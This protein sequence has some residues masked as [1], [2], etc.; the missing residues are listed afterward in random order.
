M[1]LWNENIWNTFYISTKTLWVWIKSKKLWGVDKKL[2][3]IEK[4][5]QFLIR[6][7][8]ES[9]ISKSTWEWLVFKIFL[10]FS[11]SLIEYGT[12]INYGFKPMKISRKWYFN[13]KL[14]FNEKIMIVHFYTNELVNYIHVIDIEIIMWYYMP[15]HIL[16]AQSHGWQWALRIDKYYD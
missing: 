8:V 3:P 10:Y 4:W 15:K 13:H 1:T 14:F 5:D 7:F 12:I 2:E 11:F 6:S 9:H 16:G